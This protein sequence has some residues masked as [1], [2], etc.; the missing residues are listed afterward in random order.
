[1]TPDNV[2]H[3]SVRR[4]EH[5]A[6]LCHD[7]KLMEREGSGFDAIYD[8]LLSQGRPAPV[9]EEGPVRLAN[10]EMKDLIPTWVS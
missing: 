6:R 10:F 4:N 3:A 9:V 1:V 7:L 5:L 8:V 2:L